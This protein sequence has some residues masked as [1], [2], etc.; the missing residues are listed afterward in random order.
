MWPPIKVGTPHI[1][2]GHSWKAGW[3]I[4]PGDFI[5]AAYPKSQARVGKPAMTEDNNPFDKQWV[6]KRKN[7]YA[8]VVRITGKQI[9]QHFRNLSL[10]P[11]KRDKALL[12]AQKLGIDLE[13]YPA[14]TIT[15]K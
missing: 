2:G 9:A 11:A 3:A 14:A 1:L 12:S 13:G 6:G 5:F 15:N 7:G 8:E 10:D 4:R